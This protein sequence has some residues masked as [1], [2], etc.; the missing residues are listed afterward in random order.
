MK[1]EFNLHFFRIKI[2]WKEIEE[3]LDDDQMKL[4][5]EASLGYRCIVQL[6]LLLSNSPKLML[7][8]NPAR[9]AIRRLRNWR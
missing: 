4:K 3:I 7:Y 5:E 8:S 6:F 9:P 2:E 1:I